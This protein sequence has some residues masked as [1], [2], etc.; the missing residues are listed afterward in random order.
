MLINIT[1]IKVL[2]Y[3]EFESLGCDVNH[4]HLLCSLHPKISPGQIV[5]I[6]KSITAR[7]VFRGKPLVKKSL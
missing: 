2:T 7:E 6:F 3:I 4:I 1:E 5:C